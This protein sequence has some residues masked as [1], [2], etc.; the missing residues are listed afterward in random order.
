MRVGDFER[1]MSRVRATHKRRIQNVDAN[2]EMNNSM[3]MSGPDY[4]V[5]WER[6][7]T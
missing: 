1:A 6:N 3:D 5:M 2:V 4:A 7:I